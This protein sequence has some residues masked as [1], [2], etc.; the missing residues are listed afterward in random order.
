MPSEGR[1]VY[2]KGAQFYCP[3]STY[4]TIV[5]LVGTFLLLLSFK[6]K[7]IEQIL[8]QVPREVRHQC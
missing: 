3:S 8:M 2:G 7:T 1:H 6:V 4:A 5:L